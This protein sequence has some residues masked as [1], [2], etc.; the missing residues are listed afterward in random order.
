[1]SREVDFLT[2]SDPLLRDVP[3][4]FV[5]EMPIMGIPTRFETNSRYVLGVVQEAFGMWSKYPGL[6]ASG[7][8]VRYRLIVH[9]VEQEGLGHV[10]MHYRAPEGDRVV[11]IA[12]NSLV[13]S[14][15]SR[16]ESV[17]YVTPHLAAD[18]A[19]FRYA[20]VEGGVLPLITAR[21]RQPLH[22]AAVARSGRAL[23]LV[24]RSGTGKSS[25]AFAAGRAGWTVMAEDEVFL[26]MSPS[27][28][29]WVLPGPARLPA[30]TAAIFPDLAT[31]AT[32]LL[33][34]GK[35]KVVAELPAHANPPVAESATVCLL[36]PGAGPVS[37]R[38]ARADEIEEALMGLVEPG[39]D[40]F[41]ETIGPAV[42]ALARGGGWRIS[43]SRDPREAAALLGSL[44]SPAPDAVT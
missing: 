26:Q 38:R 18:R 35:Q 25:V 16:G 3:L 9:D 8:P 28:R 6:E 7:L 36:E 24:G 12:G 33:T 29:V 42:R 37:A 22:A 11:L 20:V 17:A 15:A 32:T 10:P 5:A 39:F 34:N 31:R 30:E 23:L 41:Q 13:I 14:E 44:G 4:S 40:F 1:M 27:F 2:G 21:D 43:L 19:H